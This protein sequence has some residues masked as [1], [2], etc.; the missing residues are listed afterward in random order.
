LYLPAE[1]RPF[2]CAMPSQIPNLG[3][4]I[5]SFKWSATNQSQNQARVQ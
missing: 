3:D 5:A 2:P 1:E 4:L